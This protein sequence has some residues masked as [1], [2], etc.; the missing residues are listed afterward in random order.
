MNAT[1]DRASP[2]SSWTSLAKTRATLLRLR[3]SSSGLTVPFR[4]S[5]CYPLR[6][7]RPLGAPE[8]GVVAID[9]ALLHDLAPAGSAGDRVQARRGGVAHFS[10]DSD[11]SI[12]WRNPPKDS[13]F[14]QW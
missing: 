1:S 12:P 8:A 7:P 3:I 13:T 11:H 6:P 5:C 10:S 2:H 4:S 14:S 9:L